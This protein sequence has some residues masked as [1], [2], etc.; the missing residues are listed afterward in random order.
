M[1]SSSTKGSNA[2]AEKLVIAAT[3][4][5][6]LVGVFGNI[7][8]IIVLLKNKRY[9]TTI[10]L[11]LLAFADLTVTIFVAPRWFFV[12][13]FGID[14]RH[15]SR[16][17]CRLHVFLTYVAGRTSNTCLVTMTIERMIST[18]KPHKFSRYCNSRVASAICVS[19]VFTIFLFNAHIFY[20]FSLIEVSKATINN[21]NASYLCN[22][23]SM[24]PSASIKDSTSVPGLHPTQTTPQLSLDEISQDI[25]NSSTLCKR[26]IVENVDSES[27]IFL[28]CSWE[29][30]QNYAHFYT[31]VF[32]KVNVAFFFYIP[33]FVFFTGFFVIITKLRQARNKCIRRNDRKTFVQKQ[34]VRI[35][36]TLLVVNLSFLLLTTP[37]FTFVM[38]RHF[39]VDKVKGMTDTQ[40]LL[41]SIFSIM[42]NINYSINFLLYFCTGDKFRQQVR[43]CYGSCRRKRQVMPKSNTLP[44][45]SDRTLYI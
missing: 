13:A 14:V 4:I 22:D 16:F 27:N 43:E 11:I 19:I 10:Y 24:V 9:S 26:Q 38:G 25:E 41:W 44:S 2:F 33:N 7:T 28:S 30:D 40:K 31:N 18:V 12:Y 6:F 34:S 1:D 39:W 45:M 15:I 35:T 37:F 5:V 36:I 17:T 21:Q 20:G 23:T 32:E 42:Y 8:T 29:R 3:P